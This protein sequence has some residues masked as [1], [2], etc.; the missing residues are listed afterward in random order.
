MSGTG[1]SFNPRARDGREGAISYFSR[2]LRVSIH[3]PV[4][5]ANTKIRV[6]IHKHLVSI[7][8]PVMDANLVPA[9]V[10]AAGFV[11][12]H[13]PVMDANLYGSVIAKLM[14]V[15]IHAPVMDAKR[16]WQYEYQ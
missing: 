10:L 7:H 15:S 14:H 4:M 12:I 11:S 8:A 16:G 9:A 13:A 3:A 1:I 2:H 6:S 5:D